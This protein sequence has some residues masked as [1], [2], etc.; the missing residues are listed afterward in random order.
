MLNYFKRIESKTIPFYLT[1][2]IFN[3]IWWLFS[4]HVD[5]YPNEHCQWIRYFKNRQSAHIQTI[6]WHMTIEIILKFIWYENWYGILLVKSFKT[7]HILIWQYRKTYFV[8]RFKRFERFKRSHLHKS[9]STYIQCIIQWFCQSCYVFW[10][11]SSSSSSRI[12][13][14]WLKYVARLHNRIQDVIVSTCCKEYIC[15]RQH[16][17]QTLNCV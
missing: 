4:A 13:M 16:S 5:P 8:E 14:P 6:R 3:N 2:S 11:M 10:L 15:S 9:K 7:F 17:W 12:S 1:V